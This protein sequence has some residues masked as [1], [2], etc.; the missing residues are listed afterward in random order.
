MSTIKDVAKKAGVS[1]STVSLV[2]NKKGY[3]APDT[4]DRIQNA[5]EYLNYKPL[6]SARKLATQRTGNIGYIVWDAHFSEVEIFYSQ[7]F[8]GMEFAARSSDHYI[9]LTTVREEFDPKNDLP[10]FLKYKDVDGVVLAG[11]V[12][13]NLI[14][15]LEQQEMPFVLVDYG[16]PGRI[17]N[18]IVIDNYNGAFQAV[19]QL[20][21]SG[22][23]NIGFVGG[24][25]YHPSIKERYRGYTEAL[26]ANGL[27]PDG[28][29]EKLRFLKNEETSPE[30]GQ[31]GTQKL[32]SENKNLD[33][34]FCCND[35]TAIGVMNELK[36]QKVKIPNEISIVGF[37]DITSSSFCTPSLS[38]VRVPKLD[39]GKEAYKLLT[40][41]IESPKATPQTRMIS[42][43]Y[44]QR[45]SS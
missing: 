34:I 38:T 37:D 16:I 18:S 24:S 13:H 1:I 35:T 40:E 6:H 31:L 19:D 17:F 2:I 7:I 22:K 23:K 26:E 9:L 41:I 43:E 21:K 39:I 20:V 4:R 25:Y 12:P 42:V 14:D 30:I 33:G 10:R 45:Q 3:V 32:L 36:K 44:I 29:L 5:I 8:L 27:C 11:R 15:Y 28:C